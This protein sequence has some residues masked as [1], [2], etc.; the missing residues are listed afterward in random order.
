MLRMVTGRTGLPSPWLTTTRTSSQ[1][2]AD[3]KDENVR[4][5]IQTEADAKD[6]DAENVNSQNQAAF[7]FVNNLDDENVRPEIQTEADVKD[8]DAE[9]GNRKNWTAFTM[10]N[11]H[12]NVVPSGSRREGRERPFG[13]PDKSQRE[14]SGC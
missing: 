1:A 4:P 3:A 12:E 14:G 2:E 9:N 13:D 8:L 11:N 10:V 6:L 7:V 5:E